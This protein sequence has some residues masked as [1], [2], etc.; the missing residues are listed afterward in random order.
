[1]SDFNSSLPIRTETNGDVVVKLVDG[2]LVSQAASIDANGSQ[3]SRI[4]DASG[5]VITSSAQGTQ[6][7]LDVEIN[8]GSAIIDPRSIRALTASDVVTANQGT[9][10]TIANAWKVAPTDGTNSQAYLA[11]GEAKVSVTQ[12]LPTGAN[13]I[14]SVNQG[15]SPW[16]TKDL[17]DGSSAG[18]TAG[19]FSLQVGGIFNT[20]LPTLTT[21]QQASVQLDS[22][23]R[24]IIAPLTNTSIVK[25]QLQDNAGTAIILGQKTMSASVPVVIASDQTHFPVEIQDGAG[26]SITSQVNGAQRALDVGINVAGVQIDPRQIRALTSTDVVTANIKDATGTAFSLT[27]PLPVSISVDN[28]GTEVNNYNTGSAVAAGS[29]SNHDYTVSAGKSLLLTQVECSASG[30]MKV[31]IQIETAAASGVFN[32]KFVQFNSTSTPNC[33][34]HLAAPITV[35]TGVRVRVIRTNKDLLSQ[36]LYS[37]ITGQEV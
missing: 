7:A 11:T 35:L 29:A 26:N 4:A 2:T 25:A 12:A 20:S 21:G 30:K 31:E 19:T 14:G 36:D 9:A 22:S 33:S 17:A 8:F 28:A 1:M 5:N 18:G 27:N 16:I 37:T 23:G 24:V 15:T 10:N 6:R 3:Q 13:V 32:T 34:L